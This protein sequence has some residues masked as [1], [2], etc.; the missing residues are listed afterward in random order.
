MDSVAAVASTSNYSDEF[1]KV[2]C[3]AESINIPFV[4]DNNEEYNEV[5]TLAELKC[6]PSLPVTLRRVRTKFTTSC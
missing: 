5:F 6:A 3:A 2:K 4:S 1:I